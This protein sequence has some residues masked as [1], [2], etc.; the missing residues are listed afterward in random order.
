MCNTYISVYL[1]YEKRDKIENQ[2][3]ES[4]MKFLILVLFLIFGSCS[5]SAD[6]VKSQP[7][8][9]KQKVSAA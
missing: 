8:D 7:S 9:E 1:F 5:L 2:V 6:D 3:Q 4:G